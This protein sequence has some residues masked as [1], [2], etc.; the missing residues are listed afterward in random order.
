MS[1]WRSILFSSLERSIKV[2]VFMD[3]ML[4]MVFILEVTGSGKGRTAF[5]QA[6][7]GDK[8]VKIKPVL[9]YSMYPLTSLGGMLLALVQ[10]EI[11]SYPNKHVALQ[12]FETVARYTD[13]FKV[14]KECILPTLEALID[15]R[16]VF[17]FI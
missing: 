16:W 6:P 2:S 11:A 7:P 14:R 9:D 13:F 4:A 8:T 1:N 17:L 15:P 10:S 12:Y 3:H 5:C